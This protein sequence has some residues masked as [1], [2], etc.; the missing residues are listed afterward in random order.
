MNV[1]VLHIAM[2]STDSCYLEI[3]RHC[4]QAVLAQLDL[5]ALHRRCIWLGRGILLRHLL[6]KLA[7][8]GIEFCF[9]QLCFAVLCARMC[10]DSQHIISATLSA[11]GFPYQRTW[12]SPL[13]RFT[14]NLKQECAKMAFGFISSTEKTC[15][16]EQQPF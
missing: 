13:S 8:E 15:S 5:A 2:N 16:A 7:F 12:E 1:A 10:I 14:H 3:L 11:S 9:A 4:V 6:C